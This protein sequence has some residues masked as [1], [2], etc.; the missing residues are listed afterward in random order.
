MS[1]VEGGVSG[2]QSEQAYVLRALRK[3][4]EAA[5][6]ARARRGV[7]AQARGKRCAAEEVNSSADAFYPAKRRG[8]CSHLLRGAEPTLAAGRLFSNASL[9]EYRRNE[10][11]H[12]LS[13][14][15]RSQ[16][17]G[18]LLVKGRIVFGKL[19]IELGHEAFDL[20]LRRFLKRRNDGRSHFPCPVQLILLYMMLGYEILIKRHV[21]PGGH[22]AQNH[23]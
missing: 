16:W 3:Y 20:V 6:A 14:V 5:P 18:V 1:G 8:D 21:Q 22:T 15:Q 11:E 13:L 23:R 17:V 4:L 9:R 19:S 10:T 12:S 2:G 7:R